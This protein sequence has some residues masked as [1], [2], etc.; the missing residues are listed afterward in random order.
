MKIPALCGAMILASI[1]VSVAA[2]PVTYSQ[3]VRSAVEEQPR[4]QARALDVEARQELVDAADEW[5]D[6]V[7]RAGVMNF[8]VT[9]PNA[10][11]PSEVMMTMVQVGVEQRIPNGAK[12]SASRE[13]ARSDVRVAEARLSQTRREIAVEAGTAWVGLDFAQQRLALLEEVR[14]EIERLVPVAR[15]AVTSGAARPAESLEVRRALLKL[16][17]VQTSIESEREEAQARLARYVDMSDPE[18]VGER[19]DSLVDTG[20]LDASL[21]AHPDLIAEDAVIER[22]R[23]WLRLAEAEKRPDFA[24]NVSYG[25][26]DP[27]FGD[28]ASVIG[29]ITL[30]VFQSRRQE[31]RIAAA[32]L[33]EQARLAERLD[34]ERRLAAE[35]EADLAAWRSALVQWNRAREELLPLAR[36]RVDLELASYTAGRADLIDVIEAKTALALLELEI[37]E[38]HRA[39]VI[40]AVGLRLA[41]GEAVQ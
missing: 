5:P 11:E 3:A 28:V 15:S 41:Y 40:A 6:P 36:D 26:R 33:E 8:P 12:L 27:Q 2:Q 31:P 30:P 21:A 9:G 18:A 24:V 13:I 4:T 25:R 29:S 17:D 34:V 1:P 38:R 19:P 14:P 37:L 22:A 39:A 35:F 23:S 32:T 20:R 10:F 7:A 16:A